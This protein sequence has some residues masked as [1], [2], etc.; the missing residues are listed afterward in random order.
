MAW[1]LRI[2]Q[3]RP[4]PSTSVGVLGEARS[5]L[6]KDQV[7]TLEAAWD[8]GSPPPGDHVFSYEILDK[9]PT[10][11]ST[12]SSA[13]GTNVT[14][15]T[16]TPDA[17]HS[18][19]IRLLVDGGGSGKTHTVI[20]AV[21]YD[22]TGTIQNRGWRYPAYGEEAGEANFSG[23][24]TRE[25][26][27]SYE[28]IFEDIRLNGSGGTP[29]GA[30]G[31]DLSGTY[32]NPTVAKINGTSVPATPVASR[33]LVASSGT[34]ATWSLLTNAS[35]DG[36]AAIAGSKISP[37]FGSQAILGQSLT[38]A[39]LSASQYVKTN[40]S[41]LLVSQNGI[42]LADLGNSG[43]AAGDLAYWDGSNW[44]RIA[45]GVNSR[46]L[47]V[48]SG[49]PSWQKPAVPLIPA[50]TLAAGSPYTIPDNTK[51]GIWIVNAGAA[52]TVKLPAN[53]EQGEIHDIKDGGLNCA[54]YNITIDGNGRNIDGAATQVMSTNGMS[55]RMVYLPSP[56]AWYII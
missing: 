47:T 5:D 16:F 32:P 24:G 15:V 35:I 45:V 29:S 30:A 7:I 13:G 4:G 3:A 18:Y 26:L 6:W 20:A 42:P 52:F 8:S 22:S 23:S 27:K 54:T 41:K 51:A 37:D 2:N 43:G 9:P 40:G 39:G 34:A 46:V 10:A 28:V 48:S 19:R 11:T 33:V 50:A 53:P 38:L 14:S 21:R 12:L 17:Y 55:L 44:V 1:K 56:N 36:A 25:Y 31:G 49:I